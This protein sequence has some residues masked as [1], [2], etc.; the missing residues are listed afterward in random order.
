MECDVGRGVMGRGLVTE[1]LRKEKTF[2]VRLSNGTTRDAQGSTLKRFAVTPSSFPLMDLPDPALALVLFW[3][4]IRE[5][6]EA[7]CVCKRFAS[8]FK[9]NVTWKRR[10]IRDV[11]GIDIDA[12]FAAEKCKSWAEFH[13]RHT[14]IRIRIVTVFFHRGGRSLSGDFTVT[15]SPNLRVS[16]FLE[17]VSKHSE[18]RQGGFL[19][20][21]TPFDPSK[22]GRHDDNY[23]IISNQPN[24]K[25]N[26][27]FSTSSL[28]AT[29]LEAGLCDGAILQQPESMMCD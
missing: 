17:L 14:T 1:V 6:A 18:N 19:P 8:V 24:A 3:L 21:L 12:V 22:L 5:A 4:P 15:V 11:T 10:C 2:R 28:D 20:V 23:N 13:A 27:T 16:E 7:A 9:D 29:I 26:C 25:P